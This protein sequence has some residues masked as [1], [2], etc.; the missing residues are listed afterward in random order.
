M[1][2][3]V[4]SRPDAID[5]YHYE[6][7]AM[8][9]T[10]YA[11]QASVIQRTKIKQIP[12]DIQV[13]REVVASFGFAATECTQVWQAYT[14]GQD[15]FDCYTWFQLTEQP[16]KVFREGEMTVAQGLV[17]IYLANIMCLIDIDIKNWVARFLDGTTKSLGHVTV[18]STEAVIMRAEPGGALTPCV[19]MYPDG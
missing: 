2:A 6:D 17:N 3:L 4:A 18:P 11:L 9:A 13:Y 8:V 1:D 10:L 12:S 14:D 15:E 5:W 19:G 16:D 7:W